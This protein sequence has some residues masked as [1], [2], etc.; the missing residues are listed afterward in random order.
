MATPFTFQGTLSLP[1]D[2]SL[3]QDPIPFGVSAQFSSKAE[4]ILQLVGAGSKVIDLGTLAPPGAKGY[5]IK[6]DPGSTVL[7]IT[8]RL[9]GAGAAGEEEISAGGFKAVGSPNPVAGVTSLEILYSSNV[10]VRI[11]VLG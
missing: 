1:P 7:P 2:N 10:T 9:N 8:V 6:A 11:W 3:P 4:F 5:L